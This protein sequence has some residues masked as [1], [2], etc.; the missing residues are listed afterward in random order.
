[1]PRRWKYLIVGLL[2]V[3]LLLAGCGGGTVEPT[4]PAPP[5]D[6][7]L[8]PDFSYRDAEGN[9]VTLSDLR[10][11]VVLLNFWATWCPPCVY[12]MPFLEA[13]HQQMSDNTIIL[14]VNV[15]ENADTVSA[16]LTE[17]DLTLPVILDRNGAIAQLYRAF[18][19]PTSV[20][21]DADGIIN[22]YKVGPFSGTKEILDRLERA[23]AP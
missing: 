11:Q 16:F 15:G 21:I 17:Y 6:T 22:Q 9:E 3:T 5:E 23:A 14:A 7:Q 13:A 19:M 12:E 4:P 10:G 2:S 8:A 18:Q 1:M 20:I